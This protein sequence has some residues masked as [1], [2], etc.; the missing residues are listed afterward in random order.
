[1]DSGSKGENYHQQAN[2]TRIGRR[3]QDPVLRHIGCTPTFLYKK[4]IN[5]S[6]YDWV[7]SL[8]MFPN[9][10]CLFR[11]LEP[12]LL[13]NKRLT[14]KQVLFWLF[15]DTKQENFFMV[16]EKLWEKKNNKNN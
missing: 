11:P 3:V 5:L 10:P 8:K 15:R 1:M 2:S 7:S 13:L 12:I 4:R 16:Y 14:S 6:G 9:K